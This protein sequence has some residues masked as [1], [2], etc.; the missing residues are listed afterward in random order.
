MSSSS[1]GAA[2]GDANLDERGDELTSPEIEVPVHTIRN[3][4]LITVVTLALV[5]LFLWAQS[6][7][8]RPFVGEHG[9]RIFDLDDEIGIS[10]WLAQIL[11][12]LVAVALAAIAATTARYR[13][14]ERLTWWA[15][16]V[17]FLCFSIDEHLSIHEQGNEWMKNLVGET[18]GLLYFGW[19]FF[20]AAAVLLFGVVFLPFFLRL[21][22]GPRGWMIWGLV[23]FV[24]GALVLET[25]GGKFSQDVDAV[26]YELSMV[27]EETLESV[28]TIVFLFGTASLLEL[29]SRSTGIRVWIRTSDASPG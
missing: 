17:I 26:P 29:R 10:T 1:S 21:P 23:A 13:R 4:L 28:G 11:L 5:H 8:H 19:V 20:G 9:G 14:R 16:S 15:L 22:A 27:A 25:L 12:L 7:Q 3:M 24:A 2:A 18:D 6:D